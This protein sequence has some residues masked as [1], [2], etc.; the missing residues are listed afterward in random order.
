MVLP[1]PP[2][3]SSTSLR[4][5]APADTQ[6]MTAKLRKSVRSILIWDRVLLRKRTR[7]SI[8]KSVDK[9]FTRLVSMMYKSYELYVCFSSMQIV[10]IKYHRRK[11]YIAFLLLGF[12]PLIIN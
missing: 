8:K 2:S 6:L 1:S 7:M 5:S 10:N 12:Y 3:T 9:N 11:F 4:S